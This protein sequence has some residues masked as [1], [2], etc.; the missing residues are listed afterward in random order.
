M[1]APRNRDDRTDAPAG[2]ARAPRLALAGAVAAVVVVAVVAVGLQVVRSRSAGE[3]ETHPIEVAV[4]AYVHAG[5]A[6]F[7]HLLD[8]ARTPPAV[9]VVNVGNGDGDVASL[10]PTAD[11]LRARRTA[12]G[13]P[14]TVVGYVWT[15][16]AGQVA[17]RP[18]ADIEAAV[19][20]WL[21]PR[22]GRVHYD[23]IFFDVAP[24]TCGPTPGTDDY[25]D[26]YLTMRRHVQQR[27][28]GPDTVVIANPGVPVPACY[29]EPDHRTA[30]TFVTFEGSQA[31]Y[32][33]AWLGGNV[34][35][36][37]RYAPGGTVTVPDGGGTR[38]VTVDPASFWHIVYNTDPGAAPSIVDLAHERGAGYVTATDDRYPGNPFDAAPGDLDA[39]VARAA[40][41]P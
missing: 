18:L 30:D 24:A 9:V 36:G 41:F 34:D 29:L 2:R 10:D 7:E 26:K 32:R 37:G 11:Q 40:T 16:A 17:S 20:R 23:G 8:P 5:D 38:Q 27:R 1:S 22:G 25:R 21:A 15:S 14:V 13:E 19:D 6:Y 35:A 3:P 33:S 4:P 12:A 28:P 31:D 39:G